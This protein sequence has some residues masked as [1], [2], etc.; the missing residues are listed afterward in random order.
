MAQTG[1]KTAGPHPVFFTQV[2]QNKAGKADR[3][4]NC[5]SGRLENKRA[6]VSLCTC[7]LK[8]ED[9]CHFLKSVSDLGGGGYTK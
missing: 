6:L 7:P 1:E 9:F 5:F 2:E 3:A 4:E 8:F